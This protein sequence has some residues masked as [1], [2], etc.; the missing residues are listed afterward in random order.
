VERSS[1][2]RR[3]AVARGAEAETWV[4][5]RLEEAGWRIVERNWRCDAGEIDIVA[6]R[7]GALRF[8]EVKA[9]E[10]DDPTGLEAIDREKQRHV[11]R[12][13]ETY[14]A[15]RGEEWREAAF[16]V[17]LASPAP[18]GWTVEWVDDAFDA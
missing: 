8:V 5:S 13:A 6:E 15:V 14:L 4:A 3:Q 17:A 9:R 10:L 16:L 12:A 18:Q 2:D 1:D 11:A 7:E